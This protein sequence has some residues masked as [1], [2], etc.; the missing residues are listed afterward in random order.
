[1]REFGE[2]LD[3]LCAL[4]GA[5]L[6]SIRPGRELTL[7]KVDVPNGRIVFLTRAQRERSRA[8][9]ELARLWN[10][11]H[12][13]A[14]IHVESELR[15]SGTSRNQP[16]TLLANLPWVEWLEVDNK[17]HLTLVSRESHPP[18]TIKKVDAISAEL[19]RTQATGGSPSA[20]QAL[21]V[22][23]NPVQAATELATLLRTQVVY[24][25]GP[26]YSVTS[27]YARMLVMEASDFLSAYSIG[28]GCY[29][30][31][32]IERQPQDAE[33]IAVG[34]HRFFLLRGEHAVILCAMH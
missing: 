31:L 28:P 5:T 7:I 26:I 30:I 34:R 24:E 27:A 13:K 18:G 33:V 1:M 32:A 4:R 22:A 6:P 9:S 8:I 14:L 25:D 21:L 15:G 17:K 23:P 29:P 3:R 12:S 2:A 19:L 10:A 11:L 16:E 20:A